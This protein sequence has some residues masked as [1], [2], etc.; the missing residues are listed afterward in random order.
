MM[1]G[2]LF[3]SVAVF[4]SHCGGVGSSVRD[5][6]PGLSAGSPDPEYGSDIDILFKYD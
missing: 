6:D 3:I 2:S 5:P 1:I 4:G